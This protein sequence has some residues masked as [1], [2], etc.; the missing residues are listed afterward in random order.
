[1]NISKSFLFKVEMKLDSNR[2]SLNSSNYFP[3]IYLRLEN[4]PK[5]YAKVVVLFCPPW[6]IYREL[7]VWLH[8]YF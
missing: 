6:D 7:T 3:G 5:N 1:M 8:F 4:F 2:T